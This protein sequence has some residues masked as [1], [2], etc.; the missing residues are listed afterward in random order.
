MINCILLDDEAKALKM[1][2]KKLK[3]NHPDINILATFQEPEKA[4]EAIRQLKPNL[5]FLD[6]AMPN[7]SGFDVLSQFDEPEFEVIFVTAYDAYAIQAIKHSAIGYIVKPI[8]DEALNE[9][10]IKAKKNISMK[11]AR[12]NNKALLDL[13][14][15]KSNTLSIP[16]Q[17]GYTFIK[18]DDLVRL[19]GAEGYTKI[20]CK[21]GQEFLSSYNLGKFVDLLENRHFFHAHRSHIINLKFVTRYLNE[22]Y[23]ELMNKHTIPLSKNKRKDFLS[24]MNQQ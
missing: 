13:L 16:T 1:L 11:V 22:G 24:L 4:V 19:E 14:N 2:E 9:A 23:I 20:I 6:I 18:I 15:Q 3:K 5:V 12:E 7:M 17:E 10:V 21:N 8:D